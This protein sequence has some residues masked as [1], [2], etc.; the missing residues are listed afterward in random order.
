MLSVVVPAY[1]EALRL[2]ATL[3][4]LRVYLD[5]AGEEYEDYEVIV[6]DDG[7]G[8]G[9]A[10]L[11]ERE[12]AGWPQLRVLRLPENRGKGA[13]VQAGMLAARGDLRLFTDADLSTPITELAKLRDLIGG[14]TAV[15]IGS[16]AVADS[17]VEVHQPARRELMGR[18]YNR[19]LRLLVLRGLHDTQCGFKLFTAEAAVACFTPLRTPGYGF[20][21]EVLLRARR[22]GWEIAEVGVVWRHA[23]NSRVSP[24]R[25][26]LGTLID[27]LKLWL[28]RE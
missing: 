17:K 24:L 7:S 10:D 19:L 20:D 15:V 13:S 23:E 18:T 27:L 25:D 16:R 5:G 26:S 12:C 22:L 3:Q 8:D 2:P 9:T 1:D 11:A 14:S 28:R 6:V 4:A 21:A